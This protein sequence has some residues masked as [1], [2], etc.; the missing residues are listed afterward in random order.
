M[1]EGMNGIL[2]QKIVKEEEEEEGEEKINFK[3]EP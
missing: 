3:S 1:A 2:K